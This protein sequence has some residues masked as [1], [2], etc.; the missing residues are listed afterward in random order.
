MIPQI[1]ITQTKMTNSKTVIPRT[2]VELAHDQLRYKHVWLIKFES[3]R[4]THVTPAN[5]LNPSLRYIVLHVWCCQRICEKNTAYL[6][7]RLLVQVSLV[8]PKKLHLTHSLTI[9]LHVQQ[10]ITCL[11]DMFTQ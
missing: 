11:F 10:K 5:Q 4:F 9:E 2:D 6:F 1:I 8:F 3:M 7:N